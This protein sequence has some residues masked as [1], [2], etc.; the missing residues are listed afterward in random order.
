MEGPV[1]GIDLGSRRIG[2]AISDPD[3]RI[4][5]PAGH[6]ERTGLQRDLEALKALVC[7]RGVRRIVVGLPLRLDG[8]ESTGARAAREFASAVGEATSLPVE[9]VDERLTT[10]EAER[11]LREAPRSKRR[12]R[13]QVVDAMAATLLLRGW[14]EARAT[15]D[16]YGDE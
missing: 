8:R 2:L 6:L 15:R 10:V 12:E 11:A 5:F 13:K 14:L 16:R 3:R 9:L 7:E 4:A 1:L